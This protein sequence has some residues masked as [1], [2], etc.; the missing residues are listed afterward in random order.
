MPLDAKP[1]VAVF[2][3]GGNGHKTDSLVRTKGFNEGRDDGAIDHLPVRW[4]HQRA[5]HAARNG[6]LNVPHRFGQQ[7][8][9]FH[10]MPRQGSCEP[11]QTR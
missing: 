10:T 3:W 6:R 8:L 9:A 4:Q 7:H 1:P 2:Q 11:V 5:V